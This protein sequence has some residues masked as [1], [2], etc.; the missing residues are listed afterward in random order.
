MNSRERVLALVVGGLVL[1]LGGAALA[2]I[3]FV[4]PRDRLR[5]SI[6]A[7]EKNKKSKLEE[8]DKIKK[9]RKEIQDL[10]PRLTWWKQ[11]SLPQPVLATTP[12]SDHQSQMKNRYQKYL[13]DLLTR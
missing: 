8:L 9:E 13:S 7:L 10:S 6:A 11:M 4:Q 1:T 3:F 5:N 12:A 2:Y